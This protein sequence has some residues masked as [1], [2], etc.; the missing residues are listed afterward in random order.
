MEFDRLRPM[1]RRV[2]RGKLKPTRR[3]ARAST[4]AGADGRHQGGC[5]VPF[6][7][8]FPE[9][10]ADPFP[11]YRRLREEFPCFW[12]EEANMWVLSRFADIVAALNDWGRFSSAKGNMMTE[13]P[14]RAGATLGTT[15]PPRHDRLRALIQYAFVKRNL[16]SLT[17]PI[18]DIAREAAEALR[19]RKR[20]DFIDDFS[21]KF[22]VRVL[23][24][25]LGL[26]LGD[27]ATVRKTR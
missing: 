13:L 24:A 26:P 17:G 14:N 3:P 5:D 11:A 21:S 16:D 12:S 19:G 25:A 15:D 4:D 18:R 2:P 20:F 23:F 1:T 22:T 8:V 10:D 27:E 7:P 9:T 6:R